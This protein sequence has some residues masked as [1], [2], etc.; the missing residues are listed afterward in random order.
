MPFASRIMSAL[1]TAIP[2]LVWLLL[3]VVMDKR[4]YYWLTYFIVCIVFLV[5]SLLIGFIAP[6]I[7]IKTSLRRPWTWILVQGGVTW[8][9]ALVLLGLLNLTPLC[10]GQN[11]GDGNNNLALCILQSVAVGIAYS[12]LELILLA[13]SS[14]TGGRMIS[15]MTD[16]P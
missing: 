3:S 16:K 2:A 14:V 1:F 7:L 6:S 5:A 11:N 10:V 4:E 9:G 12:P 8:L 15:K 13:G